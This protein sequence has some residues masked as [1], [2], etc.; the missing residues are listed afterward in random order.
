MYKQL[1]LKQRYQISAFLKADFNL[2]EIAGKIGVHKSTVSRE[3]KRN[4]GPDKYGPEK[5]DSRASFNKKYFHKHSKRTSEMISFI[6]VKLGDEWS[7]E[8]I[9]GYCKKYGIT[10]ISHEAIYQYIKEERIKGRS[11]YLHL[12]RKGKKKR[13]SKKNEKRGKIKNR[14]SIDKRPSIVDKRFRAGDFEGDLIVGK[15][16]K[17]AI[18]TLV[19]R[20][21][22]LTIAKILPNKSARTTTD[23]IIELLQ[24]LKEF[25][26]TITFDNGKEFAF[27]EEIATKLNAD[28]YFAHPYHSWE[29]GT[30]ENTNG[31]IRQYLPKDSSFKDVRKQDIQRIIRKL[32]L[33]PRKSLGFDHP[34][35][36]FE[37]MCIQRYNW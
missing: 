9:Y 17:G 13:Q 26:H 25:V 10:M 1:T 7:P 32:N 3:I 22:K 19:D 15:D 28:V 18:V 11:L 37:K 27:H 20:V 30:N 35:G 16:N 21:T 5:A 34:A 24:P 2:T 33:R 14:I 29:R 6:N 36:V 8:Q 4:R 23:A 12:R 31:L